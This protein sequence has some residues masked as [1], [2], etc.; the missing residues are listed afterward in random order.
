MF[1]GVPGK[2]FSGQQ[3]AKKSRGL[4]AGSLGS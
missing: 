1:V 4:G 2:V 3:R